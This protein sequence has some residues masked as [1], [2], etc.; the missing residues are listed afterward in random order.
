VVENTEFGALGG[1]GRA[2]EVLQGEEVADRV[3]PVCRHLS[4][5]TQRSGGQEVSTESERRLESEILHQSG[6]GSFALPT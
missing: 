2:G 1:L 3:R 5:Q 6:V 4:R